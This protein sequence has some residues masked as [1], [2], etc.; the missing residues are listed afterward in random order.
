MRGANWITNIKYQILEII[1]KHETYI[2]YEDLEQ[3]RKPIK[4]KPI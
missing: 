3:I 1:I 4:K 2:Q